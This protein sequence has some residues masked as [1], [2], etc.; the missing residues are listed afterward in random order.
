MHPVQLLLNF[1]KAT[2]L[3]FPATAAWADQ[4][5]M[6]ARTNRDWLSVER[7]GGILLAKVGPSMLGPFTVAEEIAWWVEPVFRGH[8]LDM[9]RE[10]EA[11]A[12]S[13]GVKAIRVASLAVFPET[14]KLY[15][16]LGY[17]RLETSWVKWSFSPV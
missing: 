10:Y 16:R 5:Y 15:T 2:G 14:E 7:E 13:K 11:W 1:H 17:E 6:T 12:I 3:P 8:S 4:L 9:L